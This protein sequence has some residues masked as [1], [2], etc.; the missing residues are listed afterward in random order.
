MSLGQ[1]V[2]RM[3]KPWLMACRLAVGCVCAGLIVIALTLSDD[4][5]ENY[6]S[7]AVYEWS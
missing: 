1:D 5:C 2:I 6:A 3:S 4:V 7:S